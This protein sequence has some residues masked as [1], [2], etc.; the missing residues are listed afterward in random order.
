MRS[1]VERALELA[2]SGTCQNIRDIQ[3]KLSKEGFE[4][5]SEHLS[6]AFMR[7][8]LLNAINAMNATGPDP[9]VRSARQF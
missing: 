9:Q 8:Q 6:G 5:I 2:R 1:T 7:K 3:I 4:N